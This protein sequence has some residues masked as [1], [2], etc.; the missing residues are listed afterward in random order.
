MAL[1]TTLDAIRATAIYRVLVAL[2]LVDPNRLAA[3]WPVAAVGIRAAIELAQAEAIDAT[4]AHVTA[5]MTS[6]IGTDLGWDLTGLVNGA[7]DLAGLPARIG[8]TPDLVAKRIA[9][10]ATAAEAFAPTA[11]W[12]TQ[13]AGSVA[14]ETARQ[15]IVAA[16]TSLPVFSG[17]RWV[18]EAGACPWC[19]MQASRGAVFRKETVRHSHA[20]CVP[21]DTAVTSPGTEAAMR[22]WYEGELA[23][24]RTAG[25]K[26]LRVTPNHPILTDLG[27]VP[28]GLLQPGCHV[29]D[30]S[31]LDGQRLG[32]PDVDD[33]PALIAEVFESRSMVGVLRSMEVAPEDFYG[34]GFHGNVEVVGPDR[35]L[36]DRLVVEGAEGLVHKVLARTRVHG[37]AP[38]LVREGDSVLVV[39]GVLA[40]A[41]RVMSGGGEGLSLL[42]GQDGH[43]LAHGSR[44]APGALAETHEFAAH[45]GTADV[46]PFRDGLDA[47]PG[48]VLVGD[49]VRKDDGAAKFD[50]ASAEFGADRVFAYSHQG[51][52]LL[53]R[54]AGQVQLDRVVEKSLVSFRGHV[55]DL[56]TVEGWYVADGL[57]VSNCR[58]HS[59]E[60]T[61]RAEADRIAA[62]GQTAWATQVASGDVP[63]SARGLAGKG[64]YEPSS[65]AELY[66]VGAQTPE[67]ARS[68]QLQI[69]S[70]ERN[71][72]TLD[73]ASKAAAWQRDKLIEL[74][75]EREALAQ[76][77]HVA[78]HRVRP[79]RASHEL[80][81]ALDRQSADPF[82]GGALPSSLP[83]PPL[84]RKAP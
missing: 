5:A 35:L 36:H 78:P 22:R 27:W 62:D 38:A 44:P 59:A 74:R 56:Q 60:V 54:L 63:A 68:V 32:V 12:A 76:A 3:T 10:G 18:P 82:A 13:I 24:I 23:I 17:W 21:G 66:R 20:H 1:A 77:G 25:G 55:Y 83:D 29:V 16:S 67:R 61:D 51:G 6:A 50:P 4:E 41:S 30:G 53:G 8:V 45:Y 48:G 40:A 71:K 37:D 73:P 39:S 42:V 57:I 19:R 33:A 11:T 84:T 79:P 70:Y 31:G 46:E 80:G 28:A 15:G 47:L 75:A 7:V 81:P 2:G 9:A 26:E 58:C 49:R 72:P 43:A 64:G 34:D 52:R 65:S 69:E 14:H